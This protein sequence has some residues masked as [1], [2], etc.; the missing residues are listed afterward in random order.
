ML[1]A[2]GLYDKW[3]D[4][5][6]ES[7][8]KKSTA[9]EVRGYLVKPTRIYKVV[10][11]ND[12]LICPGDLELVEDLSLGEKVSSCTIDGTKMGPAVLYLIKGNRKYIRATYNNLHGKK[13]GEYILWSYG[14]IVKTNYYNSGKFIEGLTRNNEEINNH[15]KRDR[16]RNNNIEDLKKLC[17]DGTKR[18]CLILKRNTT[19]RCGRI[20]KLRKNKKVTFKENNIH[21]AQFTNETRLE[22]LQKL[23]ELCKELY[24][25]KRFRVNKWSSK[26][27]S[28]IKYKIANFTCLK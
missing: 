27:K 8:K 10:K 16:R 28:G 7:I 12:R 14:K 5:Q 15:K 24:S 4:Y 11:K 1:E 23:R 18:F 26:T 2:F 19:F 6:W 20:L 3:L 9:P 17:R 13:H 21:I 22:R 25:K